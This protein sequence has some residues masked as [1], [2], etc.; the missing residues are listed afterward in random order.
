MRYLL[1]I[2]LTI[3]VFACNPS[4]PQ[5]SNDE[6][7]DLGK[8]N[9]FKDAHKDHKGE[10]NYQ[11]LGEQI[12]I[13]TKEKSGSAYTIK[14]NDSKNYLIVLHEWWGLNEHIKKEADRLYQ[15]LDK[16][17]NVI[18][19]DL[20]DG[21]VATTPEEA[22]KYMQACTEDRARALIQSVLDMAGQEAQIGTI[23]WC[24]G[25]GW[26]LQT[27]IMAGDRGKASVVYYGMPEKDAKKIAPL[28]ANVLGIFAKQ[29][30]WIT[31]KIEADFKKLLDAT[32]KTYE[33]H[34]FDADHAFA[35]PTSE[36]YEGESAQKANAITNRF[37]KENLL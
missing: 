3:S 24:F 26:S 31:P 28:K 19:L 23:G 16:K 32:G 29:D 34:I 8:D 6:F 18:A 1:F 37:L 20:Y 4:N 17:V 25:G 33:G 36:R 5:N 2:F 27:A 11:L 9:E 10:G 13:K 22:T 30:Q 12:E 15:A 7:K 14:A 21:Q 35:N